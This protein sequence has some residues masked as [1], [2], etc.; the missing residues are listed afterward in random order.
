MRPTFRVLKWVTRRKRRLRKKTKRTR[1]QKI[2]PRSTFAQ[3]VQPHR[4]HADNICTDTNF[5]INQL[6]TSVT[7]VIKPSRG[8]ITSRSTFKAKLHARRRIHTNAQ[9]AV[10]NFHARVTSIVICPHVAISVTLKSAHI[11]DFT[12]SIILACIF[13]AW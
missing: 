11:Y 5:F 13:L 8:T 4:S 3:N 2:N 1:S 9:P 6:H 7:N 12:F 10:K